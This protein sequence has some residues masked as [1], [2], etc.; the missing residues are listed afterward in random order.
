MQRVL[1]LIFLT[2]IFAT[3]CA[4]EQVPTA[5]A[6]S[7]RVDIRVGTDYFSKGGWL[8]EPNKRPDI[9][10]IGSKWPYKSKKVTFITDIDSISFDVQPGNKYDFIIL[11]ENVPCHIQI[12]TLSDP[13][14][15]NTQT[16]LL[17]L[18]AFSVYLVLLY[19]YRQKLL[20]NQLLWFGYWLVILFWLITFISGYIQG[21]YNHFKSTISG[22]GAIGT[23]SE[24]F[25]SSSL[26][27]LAALNILF[28][29]GFYKASRARKLSLL[30]SI[31][32]FAMPLT[33]IWTAIFTLGNEFHGSAGLLSFLIII[34]SF[35]S[36]YLWKGQNISRGLR[37]VCLISFIIMTLLLTRFVTPF[38]YHFEGLVQRFFY[39]GWSVWTLG[40]S[41][42]LSKG[43]KTK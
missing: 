18:A 27:I 2:G 3:T 22:L 13:V 25:T 34:G 32:S 6:S 16:L 41:H 23:K 31:L 24:R 35:L 17:L 38:G 43:V 42:Y 36:Y 1:L 9:F 20:A 21:N 40:I 39:L 33:T 29:I 30:P 10:S 8:L 12:A 4:Q 5:M 37:A 15:L 7:D 26:M 28:C 14:F 11:K 19:C